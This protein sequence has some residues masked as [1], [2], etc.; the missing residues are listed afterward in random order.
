MSTQ[1]AQDGCYNNFERHSI[2]TGLASSASL[3]RTATLARIRNVAAQHVGCVPESE[4]TSTWER[5]CSAMRATRPLDGDPPARQ[6]HT[7][8]ARAVRVCVAFLLGVCVAVLLELTGLAKPVSRETER[9]ILDLTGD[10]STRSRVGVGS[11]A[12]QG[13]HQWLR[14]HNSEEVRT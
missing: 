10:G 6:T 1:V 5:K 11:V 13:E 2:S 3:G 9:K 7:N 14:A 8:Q 4:H 12:E